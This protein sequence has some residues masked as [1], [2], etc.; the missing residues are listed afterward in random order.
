[1]Q[2][3]LGSVKNSLLRL[4]ATNNEEKLAL[5]QGSF[6]SPAEWKRDEKKVEKTPLLDM[7]SRRRNVISEKVFQRRRFSSHG[8][9]HLK[10][11]RIRPRGCAKKGNRGC[12]RGTSLQKSI[13]TEGLAEEKRVL[14]KALHIGGPQKGIVADQRGKLRTYIS[15]RGRLARGGADEK[16]RG[17]S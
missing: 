1:L 6:R 15:L 4:L 17:G 2:E 14:G 3:I 9:L 13:G 7:S 16:M 5:E 11:E 10:S 12:S 8:A